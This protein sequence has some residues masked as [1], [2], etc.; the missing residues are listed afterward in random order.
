MKVAPA[1]Y[2]L[3]LWTTSLQQINFVGHVVT[4]CELCVLLVS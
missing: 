1:D 4:S 3:G 2:N